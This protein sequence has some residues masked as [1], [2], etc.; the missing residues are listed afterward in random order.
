MP[1]FYVEIKL[2]LKSDSIPFL[3]MSL[4]KDLIK[5]WK[6]QNRVRVD[7]SLNGNT[8][9]LLFAIYLNLFQGIKNKVVKKRNFTFLFNPYDIPDFNIYLK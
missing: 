6:Y 9:F 5:I 4:D 3:T 7:W 8:D 2:D 1:N